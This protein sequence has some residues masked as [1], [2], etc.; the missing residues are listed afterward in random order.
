MV[1][2]TTLRPNNGRAIVKREKSEVNAVEEVE[3]DRRNTRW[4]LLVDSRYKNEYWNGKR[5]TISCAARA[6]TSKRTSERSSDGRFCSTE[7]YL[8]RAARH[9]PHV[10]LYFV[11]FR[12]AAR[13][14]P[15]QCPVLS[16]CSRRGR[17]SE[18]RLRIRARRGIR[19]CVGP[20]SV[21]TRT[22]NLVRWRLGKPIRTNAQCA[23]QGCRAARERSAHFSSCFGDEIG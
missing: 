4:K 20:P 16:T 23:Q 18:Q 10:N 9:D 15:S 11:A 8:A 12:F 17:Q 13:S 5:E 7:R 2:G 19:V 22:L 14:L 21:G 6:H 1:F 3:V